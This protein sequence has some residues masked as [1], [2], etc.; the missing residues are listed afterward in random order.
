MD[1]AVARTPASNP[2][3]FE[4]GFGQRRNALSV[5]HEPLEVLAF[6][7]DL[8][9][10]W[11]FE[12]ALRDRVAKLATFQSEHFARIRAVERL[13]KGGAT[14]AL[15]SDQ[16]PGVRL[17]EILS[18]AESRLIPIETN[19]ALC[20]I[21]QLVSA[22]A[23]L[24]KKAP[25]LWHGAIAPERIVITSSARL[26][27]VEQVLGA[28]I[29]QLHYPYE[30]YWKE[31]RVAMPRTGTGPQFDRRT[32][33]TQVGA[34]ALALL[35]GRPIAVDEY[36]TRL[37]DMVNGT[38]ALAANGNME[39]LP[40]ALREWLSRS[41]Q[42]DPRNPFASA[43][44]AWAELDRVLHYSD[45]L[46]EVAALEAFLKRYQTA[47]TADPIKPTVATAAMAA[48]PAPVARPMPTVV[49][50]VVAPAAS[51]TAAAA[52]PGIVASVT[53][54][55]TPAPMA[56]PSAFASATAALPTPVAPQPRPAAST[57]AATDV[58]FVTPPR[59]V[60]ATK[61]E[62]PFAAAAS[63]PEHEE[64]QAPFDDS[65]EE[66][67]SVMNKSTGIPRGRLIAAAV[68]LIALTSGGTLAARKFFMPA[69]AVA[70]T[71]TLTVQTNPPGASVVIDGKQRGVTP[72]NL[73]LESGKHVLEL[74]TEG[75]VRSVPITI[76]PGAQMSQFIE[77]PHAPSALGELQIRTEPAGAQVS[78][79]GR[80]LG[81]SPLTAEGLT[82]GQHTVT[83][84]N[85]LGSVTQRVVIEAGTT[86]SLVVPLTAPKGAPV[87]GWIA[88]TAPVDVQL[89]E[90][91]RLLGSSQTDRIMVP[92]GR[93]D[94]E[95]VNEALGYRSTKVVN[96]GPGQVSTVKIDMPKAAVALNAVP[97]AEAWVDGER[98]GETPIGSV[99]LSI[100]PHEVVFRHPELGE[101]RVVTTVTLG[102]PAKVTIDMRK[103]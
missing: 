12:F 100:G 52:T 7:D 75:D 40:I 6:R 15:L 16:V 101:K 103:K 85:D 96:V 38:W 24:H 54:A 11:S 47:L 93:H 45:P 22:V 86:Q 9:S 26:V 94:L 33:V 50:P 36:P 67:E 87:S 4:D 43:V 84:E 19:V 39:P 65:L 30:Q 97:W 92:V 89:Y 55:F 34:V 3:T 32:D 20:V 95:I 62:F 88:V 49:A 91:Q 59:V 98:I 83:L 42:L 18:Q 73:A 53:A 48:K 13:G 99:S 79:D 61:P 37:A 69:D 23:L 66:V 78:V 25:D 35:I 58:P 27:L 80:A 60:A 57:H 31:L 74:V 44:E 14:L 2:V 5:A 76:T 64:E 1:S 77:L 8:T 29:E 21:R 72:L 63:P 71:G 46:G 28:A 56:P 102:T 81:K 90:N 41:L 51:S 10:V 82:P 70:T 17:S 68:V